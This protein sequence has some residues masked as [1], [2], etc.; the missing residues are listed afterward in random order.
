[1][2]RR[3][4]YALTVRQRLRDRDLWPDVPTPHLLDRLDRLAGQ[5]IARRS[6]DGA[7]AAILIYHQLFEQMSRVLIADAQFLTQLALY[8]Q[9]MRYPEVRRET[10]GRL[11]G[12]LDATMDF[13]HEQ[14][15]L[16]RA[17]RINDLR[18]DVAH[19]LVA[20]GSLEGI[21]AAAKRSVQLYNLGF[22]AFEDAHDWFCAS[23]GR[24]HDDLLS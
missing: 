4:S 22:V 11:M 20:R 6:I 14:G 8:P 5:A 2:A 10:F 13:P 24:Y 1:M 9:P 7:I 3:P 23:F 21:R 19:T 16:R 17:S 18:N 15:V 12:R